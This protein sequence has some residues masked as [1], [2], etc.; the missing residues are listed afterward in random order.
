MQTPRH[1]LDPLR[2]AALWFLAV[3]VFFGLPGLG[4]SSVL[5][6][7]ATT[8]GVSCPCDEAEHD[9]AEHDDGHHD[10][11][12]QPEHEDDGEPCQDEC[13]DDCP[14]CGCGVAT[15]MAL[16]PPPVIS[17][18]ASRAVTRPLAPTDAPSTGTRDALFRPPRLRS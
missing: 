18:A 16:L 15:A 8:C 7:A 1:I 2:L 5:A 11:E 12:A 10:D 9:E 14:N 3:S 4:G 6:A 13:P 17:G